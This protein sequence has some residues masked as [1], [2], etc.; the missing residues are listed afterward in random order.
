M[1]SQ[2]AEIA[3]RLEPMLN[4]GNLPSDTPKQSDEALRRV[5]LNALFREKVPAKYTNCSAADVPQ[6]HTGLLKGDGVFLCGNPGIGKTFAAT[7]LAKAYIAEFGATRPHP[8]DGHIVFLS[9]S[10]IWITAPRFMTRIRSCYSGNSGK[11]SLAIME[12]LDR[13]L[14]VVFD[15][16]GSEKSSDYAAEA[17][18]DLL[19]ARIN[20]NRYT[21][22]TS[23][24]E[25][26]EIAL[27]KPGIASRLGGFVR[28]D[29]PDWDRRIKPCPKTA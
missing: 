26:D 7:A 16:L 13:A 21:I 15:D 20:D 27:W 10:L 1:T 18:Y 24:L 9:T 6:I 25:L 12:E 22:V 4:A 5:A 14:V 29:L 28:I 11:T 23:N 19:S 17:I 8:E 3:K 2:Y